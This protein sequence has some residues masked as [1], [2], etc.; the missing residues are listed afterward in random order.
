[1]Y[2]FDIFITHK[3]G[4]DYGVQVVDSPT[5][6]TTGAVTVAIDKTDPQVAPVMAQMAEQQRV[7]PREA[8]QDLGKW[9]AD[10]LL[11]PGEIQTLYQRSLGRAGLEALCIRLSLPDE[12]IDVPWEYTWDPVAHD[13]LL[14]TQQVLL[15]RRP[16]EMSAA[17]VPEVDGA[18]HM[19][20]VISDIDD[21]N[22]A[23]LDVMRELDG[24]HRAVEGLL[25]DGALSVDILF[26]GRAETRAEIAERAA[27]W[28]GAVLLETPLT[29]DELV[30]T[31][32]RAVHILH[33]IGHGQNDPQQGGQL[34]LTDKHGAMYPFGAANLRAALSGGDSLGLVY[35]NACETATPNTGRDLLSMA[36]ALVKAQVPA[37]VAMQYQVPDRTATSFA[38]AFYQAVAGG[39]P[40]HLALTKGRQAVRAIARRLDIDWGIPVLYLRTE[41]GIVWGKAGAEDPDKAGEG[42]YIAGDQT[43]IQGGDYVAGDKTTEANTA[44]GD[45]AL[46]GVSFGDGASIVGGDSIRTGDVGAASVVG[47]GSVSVGGNVYDGDY[48]DAQDGGDT[49]AGLGVAQSDVEALRAELV[50]LRED[51]KALGD[52][53]Q[54]EQAMGLLDDLED[55]LGLKGGAVRLTRF[56]KRAERLV[57]KVPDLADSAQDF[58][59]IVEEIFG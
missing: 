26:G 29:P 28:P 17:R 57:K 23:R 20:L 42:V 51:A 16:V 40:L 58:V 33:Y 48:S 14:L 25:Q 27:G 38:R 36:D 35:L 7:K 44:T 46:S 52:R 32:Q 8:L 43:N 47:R 31:L 53:R 6:G 50:Y 34:L 10:R 13:F 22:I 24:L 30:F 21:P 15:V 12:L 39:E 49:L 5:G 1:M 19:L 56:R 59:E 45:I 41:D 37:V 54:V 3:S 55:A 9:L 4:S 18:L 11:P 2:N